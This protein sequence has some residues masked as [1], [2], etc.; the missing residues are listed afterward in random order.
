MKKI[1]QSLTC[2]LMLVGAT[3]FA[4]TPSPI[5]FGIKAGANFTNIST[6]LKDYS[7]KAAT[8]FGIG[9]M[10]RIDI[11]KTYIQA[12]LLYAEKKSKF[13]NNLGESTTS[14]SKQ[15][16]IPVVIGH[17][18][19]KLPMVSL[20]GFA[21]G[22]YTNTIDDKL[23]GAKIE[24]TVKFKDFDK[25]N[26]GY[27]VGVGVDVL[28]FTLDVSYDGSF[29]KTNKEIGAKPNTWMVSLGYFFL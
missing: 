4:Q 29:S 19:L 8:G 11:K 20:R 7:S 18:F 10:T 22:V 28:T 5:H 26:I 1:M 13:E 6:D 14:T 15:L 23:S 16:E 21:G 3:A 25:N 27:R 12:E 17:K 24:E 9:A 2:A